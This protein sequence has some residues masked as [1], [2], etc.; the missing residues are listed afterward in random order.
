[1]DSWTLYLRIRLQKY[2]L[3][4]LVKIK[5][6]YELIFMI[7]INFVQNIKQNIIG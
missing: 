6:I 4:F 5:I 3:F 1:M 2:L 7:K